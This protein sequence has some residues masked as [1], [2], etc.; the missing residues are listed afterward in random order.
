MSLL[1]LPKPLARSHAR[2]V[3]LMAVVVVGLFGIAPIAKA[4]ELIAPQPTTRKFPQGVFCPLQ[5]DVTFVAD[6]PA[7][8]VRFSTNTVYY[9][10][11]F[12]NDNLHWSQQL[13]DNI[14]IAPE[15]TYQAHK[16]DRHSPYTDCYL[17]DLLGPTTFYFQQAGVIPLLQTFSTDP[18]LKGWDLSHG[19]YWNQVDG[20]TSD[21]SV[22]NPPFVAGCLGLGEQSAVPAAD[23]SASTEIIVGGLTAG[24]TYRLTGWWSVVDMQEEKIRLWVRVFGNQST[25]LVRESWGMVRRRWH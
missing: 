16:G 24:Q 12:D 2:S 15:A 3:S 5:I 7:C 18:G 8:L 14:C 10:N 4:Q 6:G 20:A 13:L 17:N 21:P 11:S 25:P 19:A 22:D 23:D 9:P 1:R